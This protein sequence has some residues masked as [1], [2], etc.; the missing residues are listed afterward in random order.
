MQ[1]YNTRTVRTTTEN[2]N[3]KPFGAPSAGAL[4]S[5][6]QPTAAAA[7]QAQAQARAGATNKRAALG[8]ISNAAKLKVAAK[9][10]VRK[11]EKN[12]KK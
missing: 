1:S 4:S 12:S 6:A 8:D 7:L 11:V 3:A 9:K 5:V 10:T 2:M